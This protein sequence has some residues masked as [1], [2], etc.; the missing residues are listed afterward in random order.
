MVDSVWNIS[1]GKTL[2]KNEALKEK[3]VFVLGA[4]SSAEHQNASL[5]R[6]FKN[7][8][9]LSKGLDFQDIDLGKRL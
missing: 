7:Q 8:L 2:R 1:R 4:G 3:T 5:I 9:L 6:K